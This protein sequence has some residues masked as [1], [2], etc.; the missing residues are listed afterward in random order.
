[1][2]GEGDRAGRSCPRPV[3][4]SRSD[5]LLP[6]QWHEAICADSKDDA[7]VALLVSGVVGVQ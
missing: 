6:I 4:L 7:G 3:A 2:H 1:M 5:L